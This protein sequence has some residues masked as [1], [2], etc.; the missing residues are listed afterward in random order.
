MK[1]NRPL[2]RPRKPIRNTGIAELPRPLQ[3]YPTVFKWAEV[4]AKLSE[5]GK[6]VE[7][8]WSWPAKAFDDRPNLGAAGLNGYYTMSGH[9][10]PG[11]DPASLAEDD[12]LFKAAVDSG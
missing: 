5:S 9:R 4:V 12:L 3:Q 7:G 1:S 8:A 2:V 11:L 6:P 10:C